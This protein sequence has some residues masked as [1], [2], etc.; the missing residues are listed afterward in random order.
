[1]YKYTYIYICTHIHIFTYIY[2]NMYRL[3]LSKVQCLNMPSRMPPWG[4]WPSGWKI[5]LELLKRYIC[6]NICIY[7]CI[8]IYIY[9]YIYE[10]I[11]YHHHAYTY[12]S[13][14]L[15]LY[16]RRRSV[17]IMQFIRHASLHFSVT[18]RPFPL[19]LTTPNPYLLTL[20][21]I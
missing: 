10:Y 5:I 9:I 20:Y 8:Y 4:K 13:L 15:A 17:H 21:P 12:T 18:P 19:A 16:G 7:I 1:M 2:I 3:N 11:Y 14:L 6:I